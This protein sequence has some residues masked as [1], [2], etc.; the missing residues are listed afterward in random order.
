MMAQNTLTQNVETAAEVIKEVK[1]AIIEKGVEVP[2]GMHATRYPEL[3]AQITSETD[4]SYLEEKIDEN[5][6]SIE[7]IQKTTIWGHTLEDDI[8]GDLEEAGNIHFSQDDSYT[9]G[10]DE[11][12][13]SVVY[14]RTALRTGFV[15][16]MGDGETGARING[17]ASIAIQ[18]S[19]KDVQRGYYPR[20]VFYHG[21]EETPTSAI[22]ERIPGTLS[23][24][25]K[26]AIGT[27]Q[28]EE[29][30]YTLKIAEGKSYLG[31]PTYIHG[32]L[33][34]GD[35]KTISTDGKA[36]CT[37]SSTGFMA[38]TSN[39]HPYINFYHSNA[40]EATST[41]IEGHEG[42]LSIPKKLRIGGTATS[43][44]NNELYVEGGG[45]FTGKVVVYGE[46]PSI[47]VGNGRSIGFR[48]RDDSETYDLVRF[49]SDNDSV[50]GTGSYN[51]GTTS[52]FEGGSVRIR[53]KDGDISLLT[54]TGTKEAIR[55]NNEGNIGIGTGLP[56]HTLHVN[57]TSCFDKV[58]YF[59]GT[60]YMGE[61][62]TNYQDGN[63]GICVS[64][65]QGAILLQTSEDS[66]ESPRISFYRGSST[67][68][69][70]LAEGY[71]GVLSI[72]NKL[73]IGEELNTDMRYALRVKGISYHSSSVYLQNDL[74]IGTDKTS[75]A[76]GQPGAALDG[77][78][79]LYLTSKENPSIN[80][81]RQNVSENA[82]SRIIEAYNNI[83]SLPQKLSVG[84]VATTNTP[85]TLN[86]TGNSNFSDIV[87]HQTAI[88]LGK[89]KTRYND[90]LA[91]ITLSPIQPY[92][93]LTAS[94]ES[95]EEPRVV[96]GKGTEI[97][98]RVQE[99][100]PGVLT[101]QTVTDEGVYIGK[102]I[103]RDSLDGHKLYVGGSTYTH[104]S[105]Y[106]RTNLYVGTEKK[107]QID[108]NTGVA[109][110]GSDGRIALCTDS[111]GSQSG[112][113]PG[114][115]FYRHG[116]TSTTSTLI[117]AH[118]GVLSMVSKLHIGPTEKNV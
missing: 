81:Y 13:P 28:N 4:L 77:N 83:L 5:K 111:S 6:K 34:T 33:Y 74:Y 7:E 55:I 69:A 31:G 108:G 49:N 105:S 27:T 15:N 46:G 2:E 24:P 63:S 17:D 96:F 101:L 110:I 9:V 20:I 85:Y 68:T 60:I 43:E 14:A 11:I 106:H 82:T 70:R 58:S 79:H 109:L 3:I 37:M 102:N 113:N 57:G 117:K 93:A 59:K 65:N 97:T 12:R 92:I 38:I 45:Y 39:E 90:G 42:I 47:I 89:N 72:T 56:D 100:Y 62:K 61:N 75:W 35:D 52:F 32:A 87:Y 16:A 21:S 23:I 51:N 66:T 54:G 67:Y 99:G 78:G 88:Y 91:G 116:A 18:T 64:P 73:N 115:I 22:R 25:D 50:F 29:M 80:F 104:E 36:G 103:K 118:N 8:S 40:T 94:K 71:P 26:L 41:L 84:A 48:T 10:S 30:D 114:I 53:A 1:E 76:G 86:V 95:E 44:Q 112:G 98:S 107:G 19:D